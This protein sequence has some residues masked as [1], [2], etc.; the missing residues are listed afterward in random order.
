MAT[1]ING[2]RG[3]RGRD[4]MIVGYTTIYAIIY[5]TAHFPDLGQTL[6]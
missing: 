6:Q 2:G 1:R 4:H 3:H 5:M